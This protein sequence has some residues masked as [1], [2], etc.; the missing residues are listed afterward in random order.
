MFE[1][2]YI[3]LSQSAVEHNIRFLK[4]RVGKNVRISSVVKGNAYGH[5]IE[6]W[7]P[8]VARAGINHFS[9]FSAV[10]AE[11]V[12]KVAPENCTLMIMGEVS[13]QALEWAISNGIAFFVFDVERLRAAISM[14]K[15][16]NIPAKVHIEL[17]TGMNRT[18]FSFQE[19]DVV[20]ELLSQNKDQ[21]IFS[22]L[23]THYAGAESIA[24]YVRVQ[25]QIR[26]FKAGKHYFEQQSLQPQIGHTSCSAA[27]MMYPKNRYDLVRIGIMQY[28]FW[29]GPEVFIHYVS[30][31]KSKEDP[32]K[33]VIS[34]KSKVMAIKEVRTGEFVGYG[35]SYLA[36]ENMRT[37][38]VPI[39]YS[40]GFSRDL[41][42]QGRVLIGGKRVAVVGLINMNMLL[43]DIT[44]V[45]GVKRG[46][47]V[48]LI[49]N[50][51]DMEI[52]VASFSEISHQ[53]NYEILTRLPESI[54]RK[55]VE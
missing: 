3:T 11:R 31:R 42:N 17:E 40:D 49:G 9:T 16:L 24:N 26:K 47:E 20:S 46:D 13:G 48:V 28:G 30:D 53:I 43:A 8:L 7:V 50:Q 33:R 55:I 15:R 10:E 19:L 18:G 14:S 38:V 54:P 39:G 1:E 23:C 41:S 51:G 5:G 45:P 34:W 35:Q 25:R 37:A 36:R 44:D 6:Q 29:P 2:S 52:S 27:M 22:G 32:L 12:M 21:L 4:R